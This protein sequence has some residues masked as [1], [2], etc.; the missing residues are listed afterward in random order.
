VSQELDKI[1]GELV[2]LT[3]EVAGLRAELANVQNE[4]GPGMQCGPDIMERPASGSVA[5]LTMMPFDLADE[6]ATTFSIMDQ[7]GR[8]NGV[9]ILG[10]KKTVGAGSSGFTWNGSDRW[11][12][13]TLSAAAYVYLKIDRTSAAV[14]IERGSSLPDDTT[15]TVEYHGLWYIPWAS[16][17]IDWQNAVDLRTMVRLSGMV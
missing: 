7:Q 17:A 10:V 4:D 1:R 13:G 16:S 8:S 3:A 2:R 15:G 6:A 12:S 9:S 5:P 14:S 11:T